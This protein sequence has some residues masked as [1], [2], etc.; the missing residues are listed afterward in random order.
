MKASQIMDA[1]ELLAKA[2][3]PVHLDGPPGVGKTSVIN[4][5]AKKMKHE[6][7][8]T[9]LADHES[10]DFQVPYVDVAKGV[11]R[12]ITSEEFP[13]Q[14]CK[15]TFWFFDEWRQGHP[16]VQNVA[17]RLL[18]E[19]RLGKYQVPDNVY[20]CAASNRAKD[21][22]A[23]N[24]MPSHIADRFNHLTMEA[25]I[26]DWTSW[27]INA[28]IET[29]VIAF[30][31]WKSELLSAFDPNADVSPTCRS[32]QKVSETLAE[33]KKARAKNKDAFPHAVE[34][35]IHAGHIGNGAAAEL[36][37]F[38]P[39][40]RTLPD[41]AAMLMN[42]DQCALPTEPATLCALAGALAKRATPNNIDRVVRIGNRLQDEFSVL[43][44]T[45]ALAYDAS[46]SSTKAFIS[47]ANAHQEAMS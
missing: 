30:L 31:R 27:A 18:N 44:I 5:V 42:P 1:V 3:L 40:F 24:R 7:F 9:R 32:W 26:H 17:G 38:L 21:R 41:P 6:V 43:M 11:L 4:Q 45:Q 22:A 20:I 46:L 37:G 29:E 19:R 25:D 36:M 35:R 12:Y 16:Q 8:I 28:G 15:P 39:I 47:W 34:E 23:T 14:G 10:S 13:K 33:L 2:R